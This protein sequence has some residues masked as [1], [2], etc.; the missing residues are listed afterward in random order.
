MSIYFLR[1]EKRNMDNPT[2]YT[3]LTSEGHYNAN[4]LAKLLEQLKI[5]KIYCSPFMRCLQTIKPFV[6]KTDLKVCVDWGLQESFYHPLFYDHNYTDLSKEEKE[7]Y[8]VDKKY[9]S[10]LKPNVLRYQEDTG[11]FIYRVKKFFI[12]LKLENNNSDENIL[13]CTHMGV[14]NVLL[15]LFKVDRNLMSLYKMGRVSTVKNNKLVYIN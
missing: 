6:D 9:K 4:G 1:H 2:F 13:I 12:N 10:T 5:T 15:T 11:S 14:I 3:N 7:C 8:H